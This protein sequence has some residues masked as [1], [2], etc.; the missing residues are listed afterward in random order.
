MPAL[1]SLLAGAAAALLLS[2]CASSWLPRLP[3][4]ASAAPDAAAFAARQSA[5]AAASDAAQPRTL[6]TPQAYLALIAQ[7]RQSGQHY[8]A[9]AHI[10]AYEAQHGSSPE[11]TLLKADTLRAIG[12]AAEAAQLY[13]QLLGT[14]LAPRAWHGLGLVAGGRQDFAAA[15]AL[16]ERAA[17][18]E[19][20]NATLLSDYGY[21]L[22]RSG[23][24]Q[25]ARRPLMT[26]AELAPA[27]PRIQANLALYQS[28]VQAAASA[29]GDT[30]GA[31]R[32][33][34]LSQAQQA[35]RLALGA[36]PPAATAAEPAALPPAS[37]GRLPPSKT[38]G[39]S[40]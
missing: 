30:A 10:Q 28:E 9:H 8:A 1:P 31:P 33:R 22:L 3:G 14:P 35:M 17:A 13:G 21:A 4:T 5:A 15:A 12:E 18:S 39:K 11:T 7:L 34:G 25:Q 27:D 38:L 24:L 37:G 26:A 16:L 2:G 6:D 29:R 32:E 20:T 19:A 23:R 40:Q 36:E